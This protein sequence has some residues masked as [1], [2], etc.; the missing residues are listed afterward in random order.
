[1]QGN[2]SLLMLDLAQASH[3]EQIARAERNQAVAQILNRNAGARLYGI[4]RAVGQS[5][6]AIGER[7]R[8]EDCEQMVEEL[9]ADQLPL[10]LAR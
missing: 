1:M 8:L 10:N 5:L 7:I 3:R 2:I 9:G 6:I 4:R